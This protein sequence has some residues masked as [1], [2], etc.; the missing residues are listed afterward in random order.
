[1]LNEDDIYA[2]S[3]PDRPEEEWEPLRHHLRGVGRMAKLFASAFDAGDWGTAA[4]LLH[5]VGKYLVAFQLYIR[6]KGRGVWH[7]PQGARVAQCKF[8]SGP[9]RIVAYTVAGHH[10]GLHD[11]GELDKRLNWARDAT[12]GGYEAYADALDLPTALQLPPAFLANGPLEK[13]E[14][15]FALSFFV[16]MLFSCLID[17]DRLCTERF[18]APE[19]YRTRKESRIPLIEIKGRVDAHLEKL[20]RRAAE[21][22]GPVNAIRSEVLSHCRAAAELSPG[23]FSLTVPTGGGKTLSSLAFALDHAL[24]HGLRRIVYVIPHTSIIEQTCDVF[25]EALGPDLSAAVLEHHSAFVPPNCDKEEEIG[26]S[27]LR[28]AT[29]NWDVPIVVTTS[30]QFFES[31]FSAH[32][33][34]TRKLHNLAKSVVIL[35]EAQALPTPRLGPCVAALNELVRRYGNSTVLCTATQ[36]PLTRGR[37]LPVGLETVREIVPD[38]SRLSQRLK[39]VKAEFEGR[40]SDADLADRISEAPRVLCIVDTRAQARDLF[41]AVRKRLGEAEGLLHL[42]AA[43][44]PIHRRSVLAE[45]RSRLQDGRP[46][47]LVATQVIEAG[48]DVDFPLVFRGLAGID[49]LAQA[50]GR[51]NREGRLADLG[52]LVVFLGEGRPPPGD[53][54]R[55]RLLAQGLVEKAEDPLTPETVQRFFAELFSVTGAKGLDFDE[56]VKGLAETAQQARWP[57]RSIGSKFKMIDEQTFPV[58]VDWQNEKADALQES[59]IAEL[60]RLTRQSHPV[61][62]RLLRSLQQYT[63]SL[64]P[65]QFDLL[66]NIGAVSLLGPDDAF[67]RLS[68]P[69]FYDRSVGLVPGENLRAAEENII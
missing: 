40:L 16:R 7:A 51:C 26:P 61:P 15:G 10:A 8:A 66:R 41:T 53:L 37:H 45:V 14:S 46:C 62:L 36:P 52:R 11:A 32:P 56:I 34:Q 5:D 4:G 12:E 54:Q 17:A 2:H 18:Y 24:R 57:F 44:C 35:D 20:Q 43:M 47:R 68:Q 42:S 13:L 27:K 50:A 21:Q 28:L 64:R 6:G 33:R 48:V 3:L 25:R 31:L 49:A 23:A 1:M 39:R 22:T 38:P 19:T 63:V 29:D 30:V 55:R 69:D 67:S 65:H 59:P 60:E 9:G 58:L